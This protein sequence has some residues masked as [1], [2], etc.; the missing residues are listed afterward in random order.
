MT[1]VLET[2]VPA[3]FARRGIQRQVVT[4]EPLY[5]ATFVELL[6]RAFHWKHLLDADAQPSGAAIA[7]E[8]GLHH[9]TVTDLLRLTLLAPDIIDRF[10]AGQQPSQFTFTAFRQWPL[11]VVWDAQ[12]ELIA[13]FD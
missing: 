8:E 2:F 6:G 12:R 11:P 9:T 4:G 7:R 1:A 3:V 5:D 10:L 13:R